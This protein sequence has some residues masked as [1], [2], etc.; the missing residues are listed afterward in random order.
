MNGKEEWLDCLWIWE[1]DSC[2]SGQSGPWPHGGW[3][4]G[5]CTLPA[6]TNDLWQGTCN[7]SFCIGRRK[8]WWWWE[9]EKEECY[10]KEFIRDGYFQSLTQVGM[11]RVPVDRMMPCSQL[12]WLFLFKNRKRQWLSLHGDKTKCIWSQWA[13]HAHFHFCLFGWVSWGSHRNYTPRSQFP[14]G[15]PWQNKAL[16]F[17]HSQ[18]PFLISPPSGFWIFRHD[19]GIM[20]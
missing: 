5:S 8:T 3:M 17:W 4:A 10:R 18:A 19:S 16:K 15:S 9:K 7:L 12:Y 13:F 1:W 11:G 2:G 20:L 6:D 14:W